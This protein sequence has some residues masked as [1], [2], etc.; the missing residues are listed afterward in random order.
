MGRVGYTPARKARR[1]L[2]WLLLYFGLAQLGLGL[3]L[4]RRHPD[5]CDPVYLHR[6]R[7]LAARLAEARDQ[8]LVV[9]LGSSRPATGIRPASLAAGW[10]GPSAPP[11]VFNFALP[12]AGPVHELMVLRRLLADGVRPDWLL[13]E[14]WA[15]FMPQKGYIAEEQMLGK[16]DLYW[17]DLPVIGRLYHQWWTP[18]TWALERSVFPAIHYRSRL[19]HRYVPFLLPKDSS[20]MFETRT[21]AWLA[22]DPRGWL[23]LSDPHPA[24]DDCRRERS[25]GECYWRS[26][27]TDF[28]INAVTDEALRELLDLCRQREI[29][30]AF[31]MMSEPS[32]VRAWYSPPLKAAFTGYV[33]RLRDRYQIPVI[34][35][36]AWNPDADFVDAFHLHPDGA[37]AFSERFGREIFQP[38]LSGRPL[39]DDV[40]MRDAKTE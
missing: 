40:L 15:P 14:V 16:L 17:P 23:P 2:I 26:A 32:F 31:L 9:I 22:L 5:F 25:R 33:A 38:L 28:H 30:V 29:K 1:I 37:R 35:A 24:P 6:R 11:L 8:P 21:S 34:D 20:G 27:T 7:A 12:G 19:L 18:F 13:V 10:T 3:F 39:P 36:R 4:Y